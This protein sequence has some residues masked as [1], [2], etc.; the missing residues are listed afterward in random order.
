MAGHSLG[1]SPLWR[2]AL[3]LWLAATLT[4]GILHWCG[5]SDQLGWALVLAVFFINEDDFSPLNSLGEILAATL[6]AI[7]TGLVVHHIA[8]GWLTL[9][10]GLLVSG[11]LVRA[12]GLLKGLSLSYLMSW[13]IGISPSAGEFSWTLFT[14]FALSVL[15]GALS[16]QAATWLF[17]PRSPLRQ[18][19]ALERSLAAQLDDQITLV[20]RWLLE[21]GPSPP[22]LRSRQLL[23]QIQKLQQLRRTSEQISSH[24]REIRLLRRWAQLGDLWLQV[25]RQWLLLEPLL[26][27]LPT[28]LLAGSENT[29]LLQRI[30]A[31]QCRL[32]PGS[33]A[34]IHRTTAAGAQD[35]I[36]EADHLGVSRP[37]VLVLFMQCHELEQLLRSRSLLRRGIER[38]LVAAA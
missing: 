7:V 17:W 27:E 20:Q 35:W 15:I 24:R 37:L 25:L 18:L 16:A 33:D 23:P 2:N 19:P 11:V 1:L 3:R 29:L 32:Q 22:S 26:Q 10:V 4:I 8:S 30:E 6:I 31:L 13:A 38:M 28:P 5:Q 12:L 21:G 34:P 36:T 14:H 9:A